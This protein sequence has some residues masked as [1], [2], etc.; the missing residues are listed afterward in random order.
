M[1]NVY[2][3]HPS[4]HKKYKNRATRESRVMANFVIFHLFYGWVGGGAHL[5]KVPLIL[6]RDQQNLLGLSRSVKKWPTLTM[7]V[8]P[9]GIMERPAFLPFFCVLLSKNGKNSKNGRFSII[10]VGIASIVNVGHF[11]ANPNGPNKF[12]W[13]RTKI[14]GTLLRWAPPPTHP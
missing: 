14:R 3:Y 13:S 11:F 1:H 12:C 10:T 2:K 5:G 7:K 8:V 6:V 9:I 4:H